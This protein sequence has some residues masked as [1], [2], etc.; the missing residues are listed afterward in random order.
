MINAATRKDVTIFDKRRCI[1]QGSLFI[2]CGKT[3][4]LLSP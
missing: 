3:I 4:I 2:N 1:I